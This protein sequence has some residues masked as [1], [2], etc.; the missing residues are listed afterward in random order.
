[1]ESRALF[2][3][4][5]VQG[6]QH[7]PCQW[8]ASGQTGFVNRTAGNTASLGAWL[9]DPRPR[10]TPLD[11]PV[12]LAVLAIL[13][14]CGPAGDPRGQAQ[15]QKQQE[16]QGCRGA[17]AGP[18]APLPPEIAPDKGLYWPTRNHIEIQ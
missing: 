7:R 13:A 15:P 8:Q 6:R 18:D 17:G 5:S 4:K 10:G 9:S 1:M 14:A 11:R 2:G 16:Q 12:D 3:L